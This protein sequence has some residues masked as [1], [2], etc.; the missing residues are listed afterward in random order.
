MAMVPVVQQRRDFRS[1]PYCWI[2]SLSR[3]STKICSTV[4]ALLC[5]S[6]DES[7]LTAVNRSLQL[8]QSRGF[9]QNEKPA[10]WGLTEKGIAV[11]RGE[12]CTR[13]AKKHR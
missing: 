1:K 12:L 13:S 5:S 8:L 7:R 9:V 11:K 2:Y 10:L 4:T 3:S 6:H